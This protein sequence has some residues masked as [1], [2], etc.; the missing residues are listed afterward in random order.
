MTTVVKVQGTD[1]EMLLNDLA[2]YRGRSPYRIRFWV[3]GGG[4]KVQRDDGVWSPPLGEIEER[5]S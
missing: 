4:I 5:Q 3:D 2:E 1:L